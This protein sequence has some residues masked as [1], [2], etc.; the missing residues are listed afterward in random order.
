[1]TTVILKTIRIISKEILAWRVNASP[2][3]NDDGTIS[4][5]ARMA[6]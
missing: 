2:Q 6:V 4:D 5:R 1:V 3:G